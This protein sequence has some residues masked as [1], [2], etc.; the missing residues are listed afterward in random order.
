[1]YIPHTKQLLVQFIN[2]HSICTIADINKQ[3]NKVL[4]KEPTRGSYYKKKSALTMLKGWYT[5]IHRGM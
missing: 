3:Y 1:M 4:N 2:R 5:H